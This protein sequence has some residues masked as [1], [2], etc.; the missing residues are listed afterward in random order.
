[1]AKRSPM[2]SVSTRDAT[3]TVEPL[4]LRH[5]AA[6][7]GLASDPEIG[8]TSN[9]P[10]PYPRDGAAAFVA[11]AARRRAAGSQFSFAIIARG[12]VVGICSLVAVD[13]RSG[14]ADLGYWIGRPHWGRGYAT[15]AG[16]R[17]LEFGFG[18]LGLKTIRAG[19]LPGNP[20]SRRVLEKLGFRFAHLGVPRAGSRWPPSQVVVYWEASRGRT[21]G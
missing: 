9:V 3:V 7:Q 13:D 6:V 4:E 14:V 20:A 17:V 18:V 12:A 1:M 16:L 2:R 8:R 19:C 10:Y 15:G 11:D 21:G 5:A